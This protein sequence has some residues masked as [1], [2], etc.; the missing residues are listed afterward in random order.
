MEKRR[1]V[2]RVL[3]SVFITSVL[4]TGGLVVHTHQIEAATTSQ[5]KEQIFYKGKI[6]SSTLKVYKSSST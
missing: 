5:S 3:I 4:L 2:K 6:T 1:N